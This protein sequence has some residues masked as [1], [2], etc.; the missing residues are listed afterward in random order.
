M[1][2]IFL[3]GGEGLIGR[4]VVKELVSKGFDVKVV[5]IKHNSSL[6]HYKKSK[7]AQIEGNLNNYDFVLKHVK[8]ADAIIHL[9]APASFLMYKENPIKSTI[10]TINIFLNLLEA[11]KKYQIRKVV[12]AST[13]AVYE[14]NKFPYK[15]KMQI[16]PPDL[17]ALS[18]KMNE[19]MGYLYAKSY[20]TNVIAL[21]PFSVYGDDEF[22]KNGYA[23][24][25]SLFVWSMLNGKQ[26]V[27]WGNGK[28]TRDYIHADDVARAFYLALTKNIGST[29]LNV[30]TGKETSFNEIVE[31]INYKLKTSIIP[32]YVPV[33]IDIYA[34]R[35]LSDNTKIE[36]QLNFKPKISL[37][38]G[39]DRVISST[40]QYKNKKTLAK[41]Q[42][43]YETLAKKKL[44]H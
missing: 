21:R 28:Q 36:K 6:L 14:G 34:Y 42:L 20:K 25:I 29:E 18:K 1:M 13:S 9:A 26:P 41:M 33:P 24:V 39:I 5:D 7:L 43:Y 44:L 16:N 10:S 35:L 37:S 32:K 11:A 27:I 38:E 4:S 15:E 19:E 22:N 30:G 8:G 31:M 17:K 3:S 12:H 23:N 2:K 40:K